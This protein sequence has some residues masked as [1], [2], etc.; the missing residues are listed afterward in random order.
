MYK[1][2]IDLYY[3]HMS[4]NIFIILTIVLHIWFLVFEMFLW[5][6]KLAKKTFKMSQELADSSAVLAKNQG[7]YNG[8][9]A[10]GL[11]WAM[12]T[13]DPSLAYQLKIFFLSCVTLAGIY[14]AI[15]ASFM[16]FF[17]QALPAIIALVLLIKF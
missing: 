1:N 11:I 15:T 9:L 3:L 16:I 5:R 8:F 12:I 14:G 7:L 10:A 6:T 2:E 17:M 13:S 4:T